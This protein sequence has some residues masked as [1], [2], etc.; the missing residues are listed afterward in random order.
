MNGTLRCKGTKHIRKPRFVDLANNNRIERL[1]STMRERT[2]TM[3][4]FDT[5]PTANLTMQGFQVYYNYLRPH[6]ALNGGTPAQAANVDLKLGRNKWKSMIEQSVENGSNPPK[7]KAKKAKY[8]KHIAIGSIRAYIQGKRS[9]GWLKGSLAYL[10]SK[11]GL[12][13]REL[14]QVLMYLGAQHLKGIL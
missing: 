12:T 6:M 13:D 2:K 14:E 3:R 8:R 11:R 9:L 1:H 7:E 10:R 5:D 4:G